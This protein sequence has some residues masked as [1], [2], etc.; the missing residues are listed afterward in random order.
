MTARPPVALIA[1]VATDGSIGKDGGLPWHLPDD[2]AWFKAQ[3]RGKPMIMG[4][5][6]W[7]SLGQRALP[8]RSNIVLSRTLQEAPGA[9][10]VRSLGEA[11]AV[12]AREAPEEIMVIGGADIYALSLP[13]A[14]RLY[15][16]RVEAAPAG[17]VYFPPVDWSQWRCVDRKPHGVDDRHAH[18]FDIETWQRVT[19]AAAWP[20][21]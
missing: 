19:P 18:P 13:L 3:T 10:L 1:A 21:P 15:W 16:T 9:H 17:D 4:R 8:G 7:E 5:G 20:Q 11:L 2:F 6:N 12:A 14:D